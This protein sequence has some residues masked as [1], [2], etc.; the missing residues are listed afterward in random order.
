MSEKICSDCAYCIH[1]GTG[2]S[3]WT[4]TGTDLVCMF[5]MRPDFDTE[6]ASDEDTAKLRAVAEA[7]PHYTQGEGPRLGLFACDEGEQEAE[8]KAWREQTG[9]EIPPVYR[10][11]SVPWPTELHAQSSSRDG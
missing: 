3:E 4:I 9:R 5:K 8:W 7:C 6:Y 10:D 1:E 2:Y 11:D